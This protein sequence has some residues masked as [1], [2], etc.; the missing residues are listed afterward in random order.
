MCTMCG[1]GTVTCERCT[2][3]LSGKVLTFDLV[4]RLGVLQK[5]IVLRCGL[6][7]RK[8]LYGTRERGILALVCVPVPVMAVV[9]FKENFDQIA[10]RVD[11]WRMLYGEC[12]WHVNW[13][14]LVTT[15]VLLLAV[16]N[17][18][19]LKSSTNK[20]SRRDAASQTEVLRGM[21]TVYLTQYGECY[22]TSEVCLRRRSRTAIKGYRA[23]N[24]CVDF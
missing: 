17:W 16:G 3:K 10:M 23:C 7:I 2:A 12:A 1:S 6:E 11:G 20:V 22:H 5:E 19:W 4:G 24:V 13:M 15:A 8:A 21:G 18:W 14:C 9:L